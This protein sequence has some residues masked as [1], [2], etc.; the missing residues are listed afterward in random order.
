MVGILT[1]ETTNDV[2]II[3]SVYT[4]GTVSGVA[5][6]GGLIGYSQSYG[7]APTIRKSYS[8]ATVTASTSRAGGLIG[9][10]NAGHVYD[11]YATG[12]VTA[13]KGTSDDYSHAGGL[14]GWLALGATNSSIDNSYATGN[15]SGTGIRVGG[16]IG[17]HN[18]I[19]TNSY[20]SGTATTTSTAAET[21][22]GGLV[23]STGGPISG[24]GYNSATGLPAY[25]GVGTDKTPNLTNVNPYTVAELKKQATYVDW[26]FTNIWK[27]DEDA[28]YPYFKT[29]QV[30]PT[31]YTVTFVV[32]DGA[33]A[34]TDA[35]VKLG[36]TTNAAGNYVFTGLAAGT[37][38]YTV[39]K[40][41]FVTAT[42]SVT[43]TGAN[44][45]K[46][47]TLTVSG[48][49]YYIQFVSTGLVIQ[50]NG[51]EQATTVEVAD[52]SDAQLWAIDYPG[53][54]P[55]TNASGQIALITNKAN[56]ALNLRYLSTTAGVGSAFYAT[57]S[58]G[59]YPSDT[60]VN[61]NSFIYQSGDYTF[62]SARN[63]LYKA[64]PKNGGGAG[65]IVYRSSSTAPE[66]D[67]NIVLEKVG[68]VG[69]HTPN[70]N[71]T[72]KASASNGILKV[73]GTIA[74]ESVRVYTVTGQT[75]ASQT[76]TG[77]EQTIQ[78][79]AYG[80][81]IVVAGTQAVKVLAGK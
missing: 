60:D 58:N 42:G 49:Y 9:Y 66:V 12:N 47:V 17:A 30:A 75:V 14:V 57:T 34:I 50:S 23:G 73:Q 40:A 29:G 24:G 16:L 48:D 37:Y 45:T 80:V 79:P 44:V 67:C 18:G 77:S 63:T 7:S 21:F 36:A 52:G 62:L 81:Y 3:E 27:I 32:N 53:T 70:T 20:A 38:N 59:A 19:V 13:G 54:A 22:I 76:A 1:G 51:A 46:T 5:S 69:I 61:G 4:K 64:Y 74:G 68:G 71:K 26:D 56:P 41:G 28:S 10:I 8:S 43:V 11:S 78:L 65:S 15:A 35:V 72:L 6:V 55:V 39:T 31:T 33:A 2:S 25:G